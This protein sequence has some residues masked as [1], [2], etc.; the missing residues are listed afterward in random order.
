MTDP[1]EDFVESLELP[2]TPVEEAMEAQGQEGHH[3]DGHSQDGHSQSG[4]KGKRSIIQAAVRSRS[5]FAGHVTR[6]IQALNVAIYHVIS[7]LEDGLEFANAAHAN[8]VRSHDRF[9]DAHFELLK[10]YEDVG[11]QEGFRKAEGYKEK[12]DENINKAYKF[13][14]EYLVKSFAVRPK[15]KDESIDQNLEAKE[16]EM[17]V[18]SRHSSVT[19]GGEK[20]QTSVEPRLWKRAQ[21]NETGSSLLERQ[22]KAEIKNVQAELAS[23]AELGREEKRRV[24]NNASI[25]QDGAEAPESDF[26]F[27]NTLNPGAEEFTPVAGSNQFPNRQYNVSGGSSDICRLIETL[28]LPPAEIGKFSGDPL[29]YWSFRRAFDTAV[30]QTSVG[31]QAKL[32]RLVQCCEGRALKAISACNLMSPEEG[33]FRALQILYERFGNCLHVKDAWSKQITEGPSLKANDRRGLRDLADDVRNC[34][35][36]LRA[37]KQ[38]GGDTH[39]KAIQ[40]VKRLPFYLQNQY[41]KEAMSYTSKHS[42]YPG[43]DFLANFLD[44]AAMQANDPL[45]SA[46]NEKDDKSQE[47]GKT[48]SNKTSFGT[49][50]VT[51]DNKF[52]QGDK[53]FGKSHDGNVAQVMCS[54]CQ[55]SHFLDQCPVFKGYSAVTRL[56]HVREH[57]ICF[58]CLRTSEHRVQ[59][60]KKPHGCVDKCRLWHHVLLHEA[61]DTTHCKSKVTDNVKQ[62]VHKSYTSKP[63]KQVEK[64]VCLPIVRVKVRGNE[65]SISCLA[66]L[67]PGSNSTFCTKAIMKRLGLKGNNIQTQIDTINPGDESNVEIISMEVTTPKKGK[68]Y[69]LSNVH[70]VD[71]IPG[72]RDSVATKKDTGKWSHLA[73]VPAADRII[74]EV[75]LVIGLDN[76]HLLRPQEVRPGNGMDDTDPYAV[77]YALGWAIHGP[78]DTVSNLTSDKVPHCNFI[79]SKVSAS[80]DNLSRQV[81]RFWE[82]DGV[83]DLRSDKD[84]MSVED[85]EVIQLWDNTVKRVEGH[86]ELPIPF[87]KDPPELCN[88]RPMVED[89]SYSLK[90]R[91]KKDPELYVKY[92]KDVKELVAKGHAERVPADELD[93]SLGLTWYLPIFNVKHPR[94]PDKFRLVFDCAAV[95][96]GESLNTQVKQGPDLTNKLFGVLNRFRTGKVGIMAD[97]ETMFYQ[98]LVKPEHRNALRFLWWPD[99]EL[100]KPAQE[101]RMKVHLF[102]GIWSPCASTYA[103]RYVADMQKCDEN[104]KLVDAV[105]N[106][107]YVDDLLYSEDSPDEVVTFR[108][109]IADLLLKGGF[110]LVKWASNHEKVME[111][112]SVHEHSKNLCLSSDK[113]CPVEHV[114]GIQWDMEGDKLSIRTVDKHSPPTKR[115][116]LST[117]A[118]VYDPLGMVSP[119]IVIAKIIFQSECR[120]AKGWD[121]KLSVENM[122]LWEK[123]KEN[124]SQLSKFNIPRCI[125]PSEFNEQ[126][127]YSMH[128]FCDASQYAYGVVSYLRVQDSSGRVYCS[129]LTSKSRLAPMKVISIP[130][131]ELSAAALAV[132]VDE[133]LLNELQIPL[134]KS[135]FWTDSMLVLQYINNHHKRFKVFVAN[136]VA[137]IQ[138]RTE[139]NQ[140][141]YVPSAENPAD[142]ISRGMSAKE[143]VDNSRWVKGPVY[144][145]YSEESWLKMNIEPQLDLIKGDPEVCKKSTVLSLSSKVEQNQLDDFFIQYSSFHKLKK[146]VAWLRRF[147]SWLKN[148]M[149]NRIIKF[150]DN[151]TVVEMEEAESVVLRYLQK[152][153]YAE[154]IEV[155]K[156]GRCLPNN[157]SLY[158]LEPYLE[159]DLLKISGRLKYASAT[160]DQKHPVILPR[161]HSVTR[162]IASEI[163][164]AAGHSG[165]ER[166]LAEI[167]SKYWIPKARPLVN[168]IIRKC[169]DC[170]R[171]KGNCMQQ[172]MADLPEERI[173]AGKPAFTFCGT[174]VFGPF[175]TKR[176]RSREK[177]YGCLFTCFTTRAVHIEMLNSMESD[178]FINALNRFM[179]RRGIPEKMRSDNA[180]NYRGA[181]RELLVEFNKMCKS[182]RVQNHL[183]SK[184]LTWEYNPPYASHAGGVWERVIRSARNILNVLIKNQILDDERLTTIF[185]QVECILNNRPLVPASDDPRDLEPLT[186]NHLLLLR[187]GYNLALT[188]TRPQDEFGRRWRHVQ[189]V[190]DKFWERWIKEYLCTIQLRSKWFVV[191]NNVAV[192]DLVL[193]NDPNTARSVWPLGRV[194]ETYTGRD[195]LTRSV[196][197]R[198]ING[199]VV[200]PITKL[201]LLEGVNK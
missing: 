61:L 122:S 10:L 160:H 102:G 51:E 68:N 43:I 60:C 5:A 110:K 64:K 169:V 26:H 133:S 32:T 187:P 193:I 13:H 6:N 153:S 119:V 8:L 73:N 79:H 162:T 94:K 65:Q 54:L 168:D 103:L 172:R 28:Q 86:L 47:R 85:K 31:A 3:Q 1:G 131:L 182:N 78:V 146:S 179:C 96:R 108:K 99:G 59:S 41:R 84:S 197:V 132:K 157:S 71:C 154:E 198:T 152:N 185:C 151:V 72:M 189:L 42:K 87:K 188:V 135:T 66:L 125:K 111:T 136:R 107:F 143:L 177:R 14:E 200:R 113:F 201:L 90:R 33:Y 181:Y 80:P 127:T 48:V 129:F 82:I 148:R 134:G 158:R 121:E 124:L 11:D 100:D 186:P 34:F 20:D 112:I 176:G 123:W 141:K 183:L 25:Q 44:Q 95:F 67:D 115:G 190:A 126:L 163:H 138:R 145:W 130:R 12:L 144:L 104:I 175:L 4:E 116:L 128:H 74:D 55:K 88:N 105:H 15:S 155:L 180:T 57:R 149:N 194:T 18:V 45:F 118:S 27:Y 38:L 166:T 98:V 70:A 16:E 19:A 83:Q 37:M 23:L 56:A 89:R 137:D 165:R 39:E 195:G 174:D 69:F 52:A 171:Y 184:G 101:F 2:E 178:A 62:S 173:V 142:D 147:I 36:T 109:G 58:N 7:G 161:Q 91:L 77:R 63:S 53:K 196:K 150:E 40:V 35:E 29:Q 22:T 114:L 140:W 76:P 159:D 192:G 81:E 92:D 9:D 117:L 199:E 106:S 97:I 120:L 164:I 93:A 24:D 191:R 170:I 139:S 49:Q 21:E 17:K 167:R 156:S 50:V 75:E 46:L 30:G